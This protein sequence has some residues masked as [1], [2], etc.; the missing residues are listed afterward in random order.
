MSTIDTEPIP[1][2]I[3][4]INELMNV[5]WNIS[6]GGQKVPQSKRSLTSISAGIED[7]KSGDNDTAMTA[8]I[9]TLAH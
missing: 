6:D 3:L 9:M 4:R 1:K 8:G 7:R 5:A 2:K